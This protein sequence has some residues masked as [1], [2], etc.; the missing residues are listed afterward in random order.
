MFP[1]LRKGSR[2]VN[3]TSEVAKYTPQPFQGYYN[4]SKIALDNYND[5]LRRECNYLG[6]KVVKIQSGSMNMRSLFSA[7]AL[8]QLTES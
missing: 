5:V 1:L 8:L 2:I 7:E 3:L 6:I 4:I